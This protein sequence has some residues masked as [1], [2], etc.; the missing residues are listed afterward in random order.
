MTDTERLIEL[1]ESITPGPWGPAWSANDTMTIESFH[2]A[3]EGV[4]VAFA[5]VDYDANRE[6]IKDGAP[7]MD[8][9]MAHANGALV[10]R[11][12][13]LLAEVI[14]A[15]A[16]IEALTKDRDAAREEVARLTVEK[17][18]IG[19]L[20]DV[21]EEE[22]D[23][24]REEVARLKASVV[25][26]GRE[27]LLATRRRQGEPSPMD[28]MPVANHYAAEQ[29][30]GGKLRELLLMWHRGATANELIDLLPKE[31]EP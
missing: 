17:D 27:L 29:I 13:A 15:R 4:E 9:K 25:G 6:R 24:A 28:F 16:A 5:I 11:A 26:M 20:A 3:W 1:C 12:P 8:R 18:V 7:T 22:R 21:M 14:E 30:S 2:D 31:G 23:A 10:A 19:A